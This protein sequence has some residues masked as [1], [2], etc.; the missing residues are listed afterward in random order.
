MNPLTQTYLKPATIQRTDGR[1]HSPLYD[2]IYFNPTD[3]L[4]ETRHVFIAGN[5]LTE[6]W[7]QH[8]AEHFC[9]AET[10]FGSGLNLLAT[11][12]TW[13]HARDKP[14]RLTYIS[15]EL[16]PMT[17]ADLRQTHA[18]F[19]ELSP[20]SERLL[21]VWPSRRT[22]F[23]QLTLS[24][25]IT[26][27]LLLGDVTAC[28]QQLD[29]KVD[30]WFLDGFAPR[31]N[32]QMWSDRLFKV[33]AEHSVEG[34]T[35]ATYTAAGAVRRGLQAVGFEVQ[36]PPGFGHKREMISARFKAGQAPESPVKQPW[37]PTPKSTA[38]QPAVTILGAGIAGLSLARSFHR[39][40]HHTTVI[41]GLKQP[42]QAAS[43][44]PAAMVMPVL[45]AQPS[46]EALFYLRAFEHALRSYGTDCFHRCGITELI[47]HEPASQHRLQQLASAG[48]DSELLQ[49]KEQQLIYPSAGWVDTDRLRQA[50]SGH[51]DQWHSWQI[52]ELQ[53]AEDGWA[54]LQDGEV[55]HHC[56]TLILAAG[57][58]TQSLSPQPLPL[59]ARLGQT[60]RITTHSPTSVQQ[61]LLN[62]GYLIPLPDEP[63][64]HHHLLGATFDHVD[65]DQQF[66]PQPSA[67]DHLARNL[68]HWQQ[69]PDFKRLSDPAEVSSHTA[70]RATTPDHLPLCG[71]LIDHRQFAADYADLH[72]GRHW[73]VY[74]PAQPLPGLYVLSGLGSRGYTSAPLLAD[75]LQAMISGQPLPLEADLCKIIHPNRF[76]F[77]QLKKPQ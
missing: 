9:V 26:L 60:N 37:H 39:A 34:T 7:E 21:R 58:M 20:W 12:Q 44:N 29:A 67:P 53:A 46:V 40:G 63:A 76:N 61:I 24:D 52:N 68:S 57:M 16:H 62:Q 77:R 5:Q 4:A 23:H 50:W 22:G 48:L 74:P 42:M 56:Q 41:D 13:K 69:H 15:T 38:R 71:P 45:T 31:S 75:Y 70:I 11:C 27:L 64:G 18:L 47:G 51:I 66:E 59:S 65:A 30:A 28:L 72:H 2:D 54:L 35:L 19:P 8:E 10:G 14:R 25:D 73:Q 17:M 43:G 3:G 49:V 32:P 33:M 55:V 6:R 36:K 1:P